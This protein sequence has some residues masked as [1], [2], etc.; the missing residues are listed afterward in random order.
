MKKYTDK[1][2]KKYTFL[3]LRLSV[4]TGSLM[5]LI[6]LAGCQSS[7]P[8]TSL[9]SRTVSKQKVVTQAS[10]KQLSRD[11]VQ[12]VNW[13][14]VKIKSQPAKFF[15]QVPFIRLNSV[16]RT[17]TGH[18]GCNT[19]FG[20]YDINTAQKTLNLTI[21]AGHQSCDQ[22]LAQ[23]ADLADAL[24]RISR[25]Q[26]NNKQLYLQDR[27]GQILIQAEQN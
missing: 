12:D 20:R 22:A 10:S 21:K 13:R 25:F 27:T 4:F 14:I 23:E 19:V 24:E 1:A 2:F 15:N 17:V 11:G 6:G 16:S 7:Q 9:E 18:T 5:F 8:S 3:N 26:L